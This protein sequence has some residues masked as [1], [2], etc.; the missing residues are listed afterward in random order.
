MAPEEH[1]VVGD[2]HFTQTTH[3][4]PRRVFPMGTGQLLW[5]EAK[6]S[7]ESSE[8]TTTGDYRNLRPLDRAASQDFER[9]H[10]W[11]FEQLLGELH[12]R[13]FAHAEERAA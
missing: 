5:S 10:P 11:R 13:L 1:R 6:P 9:W 12:R 3:V 8:S 4:P 2:K 7:L